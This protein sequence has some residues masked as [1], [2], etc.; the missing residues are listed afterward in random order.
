M[1]I[2]CGDIDI[3]AMCSRVA[4]EIDLLRIKFFELI[5]VLTVVDALNNNF[6]EWIGRS[7]V[8]GRCS[9]VYSCFYELWIWRGRP[10]M[11]EIEWANGDFLH[12]SFQRVKVLYIWTEI[13]SRLIFFTSFLTLW[14]KLIFEMRLDK[15]RNDSPISFEMK[16]NED[17]INYFVTLI[18]WRRI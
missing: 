12:Q 14:M 18:W 3:C 13:E 11:C 17:I 7:C 8:N 15:I 10:N 16:S 6:I 2:L 9:Q 4:G 5:W 1:E